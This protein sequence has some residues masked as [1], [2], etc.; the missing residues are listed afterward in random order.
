MDPAGRSKAKSETFIGRILPAEAPLDFPYMRARERMVMGLYVLLALLS[1][2]VFPHFL[3]PNEFTRWAFAV[4]LVENGTPEI[5]RV[6]P[7]P[8]PLSRM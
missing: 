4:S 3:S 1:V 2:P 8:G 6:L 5:S 7:L